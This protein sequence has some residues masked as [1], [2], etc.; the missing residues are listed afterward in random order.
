ME[1]LGVSLIDSVMTLIAFLPV[2]VRLS[3]DIKELAAG[4]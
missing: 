4:R 2:L 3:A 1:G